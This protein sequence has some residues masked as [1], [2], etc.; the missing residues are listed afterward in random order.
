MAL[1][2][3]NLPP[4]VWRNGTQYQ[5]KGRWYNAQLVRFYEGTIQPWRGWLALSASTVTGAARAIAPWIDPSGNIWIAIG[6]HTNIYI[7]GPD[8]I[9]YDVTPAG[10][11]A[12][13]ADASNVGGYGGG[14]YGAG[15]WGTPRGASVITQDATVWTLDNLEGFLIGC[16]ADDGKLYKWNNVTANVMTVPAGSPSN[17]RAVFV[18]NEGFIFMLGSGDPRK[19]A[20]PDQTSFTSWT[21][22]VGSQAGFYF[23]QTVGKLMCGCV[24]GGTN[25]IFA[26]TDVHIATYLGLPAIYSFARVGSNCGIISQAAYAK[27][28]SFVA[29]MSPTGFWKYD[30]SVSPIA[31]DVADDVFTNLNAQ[32]QSKIFA[33]HY[34]VTGEITWFYPVGNEID[35]Y[36]TWNYRED[37]WSNGALVRTCGAEASVF[38]YPLMVDAS[39]NVWQH[40]IAYTY[41]GAATPFI[42]TGPI[43]PNLSGS[44][45][46]PS[47][48]ANVYELAGIEPD[49]KTLG[50]VVC[51]VYSKFH[52]TDADTTSGPYSMANP[53]SVRITGREMR[54][55]FTS[56]SAS[57]WRLGIPRLDV[58]G[59]GLR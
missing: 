47:T 48:G 23:V 46:T 41:T 49:Q 18:T 26:S 4:G 51:T 50:D 40:E 24:I 9:Q 39:G 7:Y 10:F 17:N 11:T 6:T 36:A 52:A 12:G 14:L 16:N 22:G 5:A 15:T 30:G 20:W 27:G 59:G 33:Y 54:L 53:T 57:A 3:L 21:P 32:Q 8:G 25:V 34:P 55:R 45:L 35:S 38:P 1:V 37:H 28:D 44:P 58:R 42:E 2:P 19:V 56:N 43:E 13:R 29:W 31:S